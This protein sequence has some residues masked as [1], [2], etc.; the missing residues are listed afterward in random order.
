MKKIGGGVDVAR[1]PAGDCGLAE[2]ASASAT[3]TSAMNVRL[4]IGVDPDPLS[5]ARRHDLRAAGA[6]R[7]AN[8]LTSSGFLYTSFISFPARLRFRG[9]RNGKFP[10]EAQPWSR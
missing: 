7:L 3:A 6:L 1:R 9:L 2:P 8:R 10:S 4:R 5:A